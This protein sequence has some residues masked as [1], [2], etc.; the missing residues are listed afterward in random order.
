M[1]YIGIAIHKK[2]CVFSA[3]N[4]AGE[5]TLETKI[6]TNDRA[7]LAEY[8]RAVGGP[9]KAVIEACWGWGKV[10]DLIEATGLVEEGVPAHPYRTRFIS[11]ARNDR[12]R[13]ILHCD[14]SHLVCR[15]GAPLRMNHDFDAIALKES[16]SQVR[17]C[18]A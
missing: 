7:G 18:T 9:C 8:L 11:K 16:V 3:L 15:A 2:H 13:G 6:G 12:E 4:E 10:H 14:P 17:R 5:R 1:N